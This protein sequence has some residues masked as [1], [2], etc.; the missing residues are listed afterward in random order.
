MLLFKRIKEK[1][2]QDHHMQ[3]K[4]KNTWNLNLKSIQKIIILSGFL[5]TVKLLNCAIPFSLDSS[6]ISFNK[7]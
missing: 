3:K 7:Y 6:E 4:Y 5:S 1:L 2:Y